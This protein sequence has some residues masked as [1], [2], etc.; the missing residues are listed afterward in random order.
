MNEELVIKKAEELARG[1]LDTNEIFRYNPNGPDAYVCPF[2]G[3][4]TYIGGSRQ[5]Q[6]CEEDC[7]RRKA[8]DFLLLTDDDIRIDENTR[9][10]PIEDLRGLQE[11]IGFLE[12]FDQVNSVV[13]PSLESPDVEKS[14]LLRELA[15]LNKRRKEI[16][17]QLMTK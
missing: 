12:D 14:K 8:N 5:D 15:S 4:E 10:S 1:I 9:Y 11:C 3:A 6:E 16:I 7:L 13:G 2:C 17:D